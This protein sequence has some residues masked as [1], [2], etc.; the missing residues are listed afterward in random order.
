MSPAVS[1]GDGGQTPF[2]AERDLEPWTGYVCSHA[3]CHEVQAQASDGL[4]R[5]RNGGMTI[6]LDSA[7]LFTLC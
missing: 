3:R 4:C 2:T 5:N 1:H 7:F 6:A